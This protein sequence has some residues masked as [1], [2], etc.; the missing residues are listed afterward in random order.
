M[1]TDLSMKNIYIILTVLSLTYLTACYPTVDSNYIP[2]NTTGG[3]ATGN[4]VIPTYT[5]QSPYGDSTGQITIN[6]TIINPCASTNLIDSFTLVGNIPPFDTIK[7]SFSDGTKVKTKGLTVNHTYPTMGFDTIR[8]VIDSGKNILDTIIK[9][10]YIAPIGGA[11]SASFTSTPIIETGNGYKYFFNS[12]SSGITPQYTWN[13]GDGS[14]LQSTTNSSIFYIFPPT[15]SATNY[16]VQLTVSNGNGCS[17]SVRNL[18]SVPASSNYQ[19]LSDTIT[20]S[21]TS[22][23][24]SNGES[25]TFSCQLNEP[26]NAF[27]QWDFGDK[28][29]GTGQTVSHSYTNAGNYTVTLNVLQNGKSILSGAQQIVKAFGQG[30]IPTASFSIDSPNTRDSLFTFINNSNIPNGTTSLSNIWD[31]GDGNNS[32]SNAMSVAHIYQKVSTVQNKMITLKVTSSAGCTSSY[33][34]SVTI[35]SK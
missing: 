23:C 11:M 3:N 7:W 22:P 1:T 35:P 4:P 25:F 19:K 24:S 17:N 29:S 20:Y 14:H 30:A 13:F 26:S 9:V 16:T 34:L 27:Y 18:I 15:A 31:F 21:F 10:I 32:N 5:P 6:S 12:V 33:S 8:A 2:V 28:S